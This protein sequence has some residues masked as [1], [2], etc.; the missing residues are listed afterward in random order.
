MNE[1]SEWECRGK[2]NNLSKHSTVFFFFFGCAGSSVALPAFSGC[3]TEGCSLVVVHGVPVT[4][5]YSCETSVVVVHG[6]S[7][8]ATCGIFLDQGWNPC[9][10]H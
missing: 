7:S 10:L 3:T 6:L 4:V 1:C 8:S 2:I 5:A 9:S